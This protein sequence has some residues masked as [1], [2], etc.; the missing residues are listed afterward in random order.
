MST[1][2]GTPKISSLQKIEAVVMDFD[3]VHTD[4]LVYVD[5]HGNESVRCSRSDG[6]GITALKEA[7]FKLL[8]L[9]KERN[10][11]VSRRGEKLN[12][13]VIQGCD[14]KLG[15]LQKW[16]ALHNLSS[17]QCI[18]VGNDINDLECLQYVGISVSPVDAHGSVSHAVAWKLS[19][20]GGNGAIREMSDALI[21]AKRGRHNDSHA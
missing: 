4:D 13:E 15:A 11:V 19:K 21:E 1:V 16:L 12:V 3:G 18:Y 7:G 14:N 8:I 9:S 2:T 6:M 17:Q 20:M 5:E 10:P